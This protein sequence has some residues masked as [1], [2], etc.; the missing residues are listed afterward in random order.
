[1]RYKYLILSKEL[2]GSASKRFHMNEKEL[3]KQHT[4][5]ADSE[6]LLGSKLTFK[7]CDEVQNYDAKSPLLNFKN[8]I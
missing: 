6:T 8:G 3:G 7:L 4:N 2:F 1:M 5:T